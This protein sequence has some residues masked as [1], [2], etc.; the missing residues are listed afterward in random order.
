MKNLLPAARMLLI[1]TVLTGLIYPLFVTVVAQ[2]LYPTQANGS[3]IVRDEG[4]V[5]SSLIG[6]VI[7]D[8]RYFSGRPSAV[9]AMQADQASL[10]S[11]GASN[12]SMTNPALLDAY[13][14][15]AAAFRAANNLSA[16]ALIPSE[17]VM[18]SGS[19]LDPHISPAGARLQAARIAESRGIPVDEV[20]AL[21]IQSTESPQL[22]F[23]GESRVNVLMLNLALDDITTP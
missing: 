3:L 8:P 13:A 9:N 5:G 7:D 2:V 23:L 1:L 6:Q 17:M 20:M 4:V 11:S 16:D 21:I 19:G 14:E 12:L 22:G 10:L 15:R 18:A